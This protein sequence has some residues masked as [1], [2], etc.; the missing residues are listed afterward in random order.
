MRDFE[1]LEMLFRT[2]V[3]AADPLVC[4]PPV[5]PDPAPTGRTIVIGAGKASAMMAQAVERR[6]AG[7]HP[8][9]D[10]SGVVV[11]RYG[12]AAP[13]DRIAIREA[14]HPTPDQAGVDACNEILAAVSDLTPEDLVVC[15]ISGGGSALLTAPATGLSLADK[16]AVN[17]ALLAS[18]A[19]INEMNCIRRH[20]SRVKGGRLAAACA[21]ARLVT[22]LISD[23]PGDEPQAIASGPTVPDPSTFEDAR[24]L[25][26]AYDMALPAN[27]LQI[28][29]AGEPETPKP[30]DPI[31]ANS[32]VRMAATPRLSLLAAAEAARRAGVTPVILGDALEGESRELGT[33]L[34]GIAQSAARHG[35]PAPPPAVLLSGGETTVTLTGPGRGGPN[36]E[37]ALG[38]ALALQGAPGIAAL[39]ADT[40]G[41]DG[42]E[43]NAGARIDATTLARAQALG[44]DGAAALR[45]N[46]AYGFF[47]ALGDLVT[48]GPT[49]TNVN[50][51][52]AVLVQ[53][54]R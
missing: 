49:G 28:L 19:T 5:T 35:D 16:Q 12:Y 3:K 18:G 11:T 2:A 44:L 51:F 47:S 27:A 36:A 14:A 50:D 42:S 7:T 20:L 1:F 43:D 32:E 21:P 25:V 38:L 41:I 52:R 30:G 31:F 53:P 29:H 45:D 17:Q 33:V 37:T 4:T 9:A 15:L 24:R 6:W 48:T 23:V 46:D 54:V 39:C 40:D 13:C 10:Y 8:R 34:A 22:I 26:S